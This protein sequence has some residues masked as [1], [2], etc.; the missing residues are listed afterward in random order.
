MGEDSALE[1][2]QTLRVCIIGA[3]VS[4]LCAAKHL[5]QKGF[6]NI[7]IF[8]STSK[9][10][11]VWN[12]QSDPNAPNALYKNLTANLPHPLMQYPD[13]PFPNSHKIERYPH[14]S[15][16]LD[17]IK[18]YSDYFKLNSF[19]K[20]NHKVIKIIPPQIMQN[21]ES[22][23]P[24]WTVYSQNNNND[25]KEMKH[26]LFDSIIVCN[27]HY[28]KPYIPNFIG[29][30][31]FKRLMF[32]SRYYREPR[33]DMFDN[34]CIVIIGYRSSGLDLGIE[35]FFECNNVKLYQVT[36]GVKVSRK[37]H[38]YYVDNDRFYY[39]LNIKQ[40]GDNSSVEFDDGEII[41]PDVVIFSTGYLYDFQPFLDN[42]T[43]KDL[44]YDR[45]IDG[46]YQQMIYPYIPSL[47]FIGANLQIVPALVAHYQCQWIANILSD[48]RYDDDDQCF[49]SEYLLERSE[50]IEW[51]MR[52]K[53]N[54]GKKDQFVLGERQFDYVK[55]LCLL[56][57]ERIPDNLE[58]LKSMYLN[59]SKPI[60]Y[61]KSKL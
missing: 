61:F 21:I 56:A 9:I 7:T 2:T 27:G 60:L 31:K 12:Y 37:T 50:M 3:G 1:M 45:T 52:N 34:K 15:I 16:I 26:E 8:E 40:F 51:I 54:T 14:H 48:L 44:K 13:L 25:D 28:T 33:H 36:H 38:K 46:L 29:L 6:K 17:Y 18:Y 47:F 57:K 39:K 22:R 49:K 32:H 5:K 20:F 4:G 24:K 41:Y 23:L 43:L 55:E 19:I 58:K 30:D 42:D 11:G 53:Q 59:K 35:I 10:G